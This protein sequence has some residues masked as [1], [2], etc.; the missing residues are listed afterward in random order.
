MRVAQPHR[1]S[2]GNTSSAEGHEKWCSHT[3]TGTIDHGAA[4]E[5]PCTLHRAEPLHLGD[6][7]EHGSMVCPVLLSCRSSLKPGMGTAAAEERRARK[8]R[9]GDG[10]AVCVRPLIRHTHAPVSMPGHTLPQHTYTHKTRSLG[11]T[12]QLSA[13]H[14]LECLSC[15]VCQCLP[16]MSANVCRAPRHHRW[17]MTQ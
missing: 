11:A 17:M 14:V 8:R 3:R 7:M 16:V 15:H 9:K 1:L 5:A 12:R 10:T 6:S 2:Q 13:D 4:K